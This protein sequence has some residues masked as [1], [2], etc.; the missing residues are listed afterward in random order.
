MR[1]W[2]IAIDGP[3]GAGKSTVARLVAKRLRFLYVDTGAMYR[4]VAWLALREG[5]GPSEEDRLVDMLGRS[6]IEFA[7]NENGLLD[8]YVDGR[9]ITPELRLPDV[10]Q[11]VSQVSVH[12]RIRHVMT[13]WQREFATRYSV[14]M[15][16]RDIG[17]VVLPDA[18]VKI[19]LTADITER[20]RRRQ[21]E[22][23]D[24]GYDVP[25]DELIR[26]I[27]ERDERDQNRDVAPLKAAADAIHIDT[28]GKT[29]DQVV[30]EIILMVS[31]VTHG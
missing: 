17:T 22:F 25:L 31:R 27:A 18:D 9:E 2:S 23:A 3:A 13:T 15:D 12:A 16:G 28:T 21:A 30:E 20:A 8:V 7:K 6:H 11:M 24:K 10:S 26:S 4:A 14:V 5:I 1:L 19:F 29:I